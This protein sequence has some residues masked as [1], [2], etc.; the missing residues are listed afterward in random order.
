MDEAFPPSDQ[1][2][3][4]PEDQ[5][6]LDAF[7]AMED[8]EEQEPALE[9]EKTQ[10]TSSGQVS[11]SQSA[12]LISEEED[13]LVL[14]AT[15]AEEDIAGMRRA[16]AQLEQDE[17]R[18]SPAFDMLHRTAH[19]LKGTAGAIGFD[20]MSAVARHIETIIGLI[21]SRDVVYMTGMMALTHVVQALELMQRNNPELSAVRHELIV[22]KGELQRASYLSQFNFQV[23]SEGNYRARS[24]RSNSQDWRVGFIQEFEIFGQRA[25]RQKSARLSYDQSLAN[26]DDQARLL[27]GATKLTFYDAVRAR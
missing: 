2:E 1:N 9:S 25:L 21:R 17:H 26:L 5:A 19:K 13:M 8:T 22:A 15:E 24:T 10:H 3:L 23:A 16:V 18:D 11:V 14:F 27:Q 7:L 20:A 4:S 12:A 6:V